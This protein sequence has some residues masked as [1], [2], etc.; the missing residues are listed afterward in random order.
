M[1]GG[2]ITHDVIG[3]ERGAAIVEEK[4]SSKGR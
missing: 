3:W 4:D 2:E 1:M